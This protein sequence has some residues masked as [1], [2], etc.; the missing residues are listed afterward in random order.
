MSQTSSTSIDLSGVAFAADGRYGWAVGEKGTI[1]ATE[2][3][4]SHWGPQISSTSSDLAGVA[5]AADGR[6]GWA[7][8]EKGTMLATEDGGSHWIRQTSSTSE[9]LSGV[10]SGADGRCRWAVGQR[11]TIIIAVAKT[12]LDKSSVKLAQSELGGEIAVSFV[13]HSNPWLPIW[14]ARV[15][16]R[17][18]KRDWSPV[19][20]AKMER[21]TGENTQ[22]QLSWTPGR[23]D[24]R[25]GDTIEHQIA[26]FAG[27]TPEMREILR[28]IVFDPWWAHLWRDH[29]TAI[30]AAG[31]PFGLFALY[32]GGFL[33]VLLFAPARLAR[34]GSAPLDGIPA[35]TGNLAFAWALLRKLWETVLLLW[36]CRNRRVRRAW[37]VQYAAGSAK[38]SDLG[39]FARER[40]VDEPDVLDAWVNARV[41]RLRDALDALELYQQ[42]RIYVPLPVQVGTARMIERPAAAMLRQIFTRPRAVV[43]IVGGGGTGKSTLACEIARWAMSD[44]PTDRLA[45]QRMVPVFVVNET[46]DLLATVTGAL[47]EMLGEEELPGDLI[48]GLLAEQRLLV[49]VDAFSEREPETRRHIEEIF[50]KAAVFNAMV[51]TSR[52]EP[53]L[54]AVE[55]T[56]LYPLLLDQKRVVPFIVDYV[57][58]LTDADAEPCPPSSVLAQGGGLHVDT[59]NVQARGLAADDANRDVDVLG[60]GHMLLQLGARILELAETGGEATPVTPLLVT[61]FVDS[62]FSR[63]QAGLSTDSM[64]QNVP[65][66][67]I[68][69]VKRVYALP[70]TATRG[71]AEDEF[72]RAAGLLAR[73]NLGDRLVPGDFS[74][75]DAMA[76]LGTAGLSDRA[77]ALLE[78]MISAGVI[79]RRTFGGIAVLRFGLDPVAEYLTAIHFVGELRRLDLA[80][81]E[82]RLNV[83]KET[84]GYPEACDGY[85]K[86]VAT[87][88]RAYSKPFRLPDMTFPWEILEG[89]P[90]VASLQSA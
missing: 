77:S 60:D 27:G 13:L 69:Y 64:P 85:L 9:H 82:T 53:R 70:T 56:T 74:S 48:H 17:T 89:P 40:F 1:L 67:F 3:G 22:W 23:K 68:D 49:I 34:V 71:A 7:V 5:F 80:E 58:R 50:S 6:H 72:I 81:I 30:L 86:A 51:I 59:R 65:E 15:D 12:T 73:V 4:G 46:T 28:S 87:C 32:A 88:Y 45:P 61:M 63:A 20:F 25:P 57:A 21:E 43:C 37:L 44:D 29:Q 14:A 90:N 83:L 47:R 38:L 19:G 78:K 52:T 62:A 41:T 16:A 79:E 35:P 10:A 11:G 18:E 76:A 66:I 24:F 36:L 84:D 55:R 54:G 31:A 33:P 75:D 2:D 26:I 42:R 8:G 39:K